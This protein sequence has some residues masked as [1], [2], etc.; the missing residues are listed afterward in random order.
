MRSAEEA[1]ATHSSVDLEP[2]TAV[3]RKTV[4]LRLK[5]YDG[6]ETGSEGTEPN[7]YIVDHAHRL[8]DPRLERWLDARAGDSRR[9]RD[10]GPRR[11][12][13]DARR[14]RA[15]RCRGRARLEGPI[16]DVGSGN[17]SP[18]I[19]LAASLPEREVTLLDSNR[20]KAEFLERVAA[21]F[22]NVSVAWGRAE[23]HAERYG[24]ALAKALAPPAVAL[25]W[26]LPLVEE[27]GAAVLWLGSSVDLDRALT[28]L[29]PARRSAARGAQRARRRPQ[30]RPDSSG[31]PRRPGMARKRPLASPEWL[32]ARA[33]LCRRQPE[34]RRRQ[35]HHCGEPRRLS[36]RG[37]REGAARRSRPAG[38]RDLGARRA[39][40][41]DVELRPSRRR[42]AGGAGQA[43][44]VREPRPHPV[45][46]GSGR[47]GRGP[48]PARRRR[49][50]PGRDARAGCRDVHVRLRRLPALARPAD[51]ER[52]RRSEPRARAGAGRVLRARRACP[53]S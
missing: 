40:Q 51:G 35:D 52:A 48:R 5:E 31:F 3:E 29:G 12:P 28:G 42:S 20:R 1:L 25:E 34:G 39:R 32:C 50:L 37:G 36:R 11:G 4:H 53:S 38:E 43:D 2:M 18:G 8:T 15:A 17:G 30:N 46:A 26:L 49:A 16:V 10:R 27:G 41:R 19:P 13:G 14:G 47:H 33:H 45:Q 9:D 44:A 23:E 21:D 7:R 24:V 22:G 6:V